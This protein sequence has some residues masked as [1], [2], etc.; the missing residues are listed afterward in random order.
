MLVC[1]L[2]QR[3]QE[4]VG[5]WHTA[6]IRTGNFTNDRAYFVVC[7]QHFSDTRRIWWG[8][9]GRF[10]SSWQNAQGRGL[11]VGC[12]HT[13]IDEFVPTMIVSFE[14]QYFIFA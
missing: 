3:T 14:A 13:Q 8:D 11:V 1:E 10:N 4:P 7:V 12:R 5:Q 2:T 9:D 6:I